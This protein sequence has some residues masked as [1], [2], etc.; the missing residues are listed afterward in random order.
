MNSTTRLSLLLACTLALTGCGKE[1]QEVTGD[2]APPLVLAAEQ[3]DLGRL[4]SLLSGNTAV[5]VRDICQWT[6]LMKAA[7]N[8]HSEAAKRLL[9]AGA[10]TDFGD[11]GGYTALML[12][13]SN[14]HGELVELLLEYGADP[15]RQEQT[16][17]W[18]ALIWA[19]KRGHVE[20]VKALLL[21]KAD[22][23]IRD[24]EGNSALDWA[25]AQSHR[26]IQELLL[27]QPSAP[28]LDSGHP[29]TVPTENIMK[30]S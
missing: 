9:E 6:P 2:T 29:E 5:D 19:A 22:Q 10:V 7:L 20:S 8:G 13:A 30:R 1:S 3:G 16:K 28:L 14:N 24:M 21:A 26:E 23:A 4:E 11:K 17:G 25:Q 15:N 12:A 18:T 27:S